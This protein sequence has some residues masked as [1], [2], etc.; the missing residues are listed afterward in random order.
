[1]RILSLCFMPLNKSENPE[2]FILTW[3]KQSIGMRLSSC[4]KVWVEKAQ[5]VR[6]T[7]DV[8]GQVAV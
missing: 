8:F 3:C 6:A 1:M 4:C 2:K 5:Q 7:E